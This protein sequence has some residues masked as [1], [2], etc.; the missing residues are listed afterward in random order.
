MGTALT[1][2]DPFM[3]PRATYR[4]Q[5][6]RHFRFHDAAAIAPYLKDLGISHVYA[7]PYL[8]ARP[9]SMHG[10]DITNHNEFNS[11][12]GGEEG[13]RRMLRAFRDHGLEHI[14]DYVPNHMGVGGPHNP[15]WLDLLEWGSASR[16][17]QWFDIDWDSHSEYLQGKLLVPFLADQYGVEL[18][19]SRFELRFDPT[20]G[21]FNIWLY[22]THKVLFRSTGRM[23]TAPV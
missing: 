12:L 8:Q 13:F 20:E 1:Q 11:E 15:F 3:I 9:G 16:Y 2:E 22:G 7:S 10:Y 23:S 17:A 6:G 4:V 19:S 14:L 5:F 21:A 18:Q